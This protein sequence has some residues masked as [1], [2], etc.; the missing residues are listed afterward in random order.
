MKAILDQDSPAWG[1][2]IECRPAKDGK[3]YSEACE[4]Y[5]YNDQRDLHE[6]YQFSAKP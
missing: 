3:D 6:S 1:R 4:K 5:H 2:R